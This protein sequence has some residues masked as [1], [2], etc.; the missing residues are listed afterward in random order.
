MPPLR[1]LHIGKFYPPYRGGMEVFLADLV[2]TQR[3]Q[4]MDAAALVH[5]NPEP[6]DPAWLVRVPVQFN[7]LYAPIAFGFRAALARAIRQFKPDILH[8]HLPNNSA[9]WVLTLPQARAI[10]WVVH[11]HSDVVLSNIKWSVAAAYALYRPFEQAVLDGAERIIATS[12]PYL[13]ASEPLRRWHSKCAVVPLGLRTALLPQTSA[14]PQPGATGLA[15]PDL[16]VQ[17]SSGVHLRLLSIGRLTYYKG[18]ETLIEAVQQLPGVEL[19]IAGEGELQAALQARIAAAA[20]RLGVPGALPARLL[21]NVS[22]AQKHAL[23]AGCDVFCL[24]SRERTEAFGVVLLEA[25]HHARPCIVTD[26]PGSGMPWV[27]AQ[28]HTGLCVP[29]EDVQAWRNAITRLQHDQKLRQRLGNAGP[30]ALAHSFGMDACARAVQRQYRSIVP[31]SA[32]VSSA[33]AVSPVSSAGMQPLVVVAT[34]NHAHCIGNLVKA[35]RSQGWHSI[36]VIDNRSTDGTCHAAQAAGAQVLRPLLAQSHWGALQ[37]GMRHALARGHAGVVTLDTHALAHTDASD[38]GWL[39]AHAASTQA[40][41]VLG[42]APHTRRRSRLA[43]AWFRRLTRLELSDVGA[44]FRH[45][46]P[47]A[48]AVLASRE[49][50][51]LDYADLG[52]LLLARRAGLRISELPLAASPLAAQTAC[53]ATALQ[54]T[55][56]STWSSTARYMA[57]TTLLCLARWQLPGQRPDRT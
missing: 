51:L 42:V 39:V 33:S 46:T 54:N 6:G 30:G 28:S 15:E 43:A 44:G 21:G 55:R 2:A 47:R 34:H 36:V 9:L 48:V 35:I 13:D 23:L 31:A 49:A 7:L 11:W 22:E 3:S 24:A 26:L 38:I 18:Y 10:P 27:V 40:D 53:P 56:F 37:T 17:W 57:A 32:S 52:A 8:L 16:P 1:V 25:M 20:T 14:L 50:T 41:V 19:L 45:Y 12:Q 4:G 29:I 5:G